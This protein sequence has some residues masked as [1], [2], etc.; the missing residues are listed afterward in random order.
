VL[1]FF[2]FVNAGVPFEQVGPGT[3]FVLA[4]LLI[5]KPVGIV[6]MSVL[7]NGVGARLPREISVQD[8]VTI[9]VVA[10]VGFTVSLFFATAAFPAGTALAETKMGALLSFAAAPLAMLAGRMARTRDRA[11]LTV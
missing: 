5:G 4:G 1:L 6:L 9:G 7:A 2:G 8:I 11:A 10:S 3:W